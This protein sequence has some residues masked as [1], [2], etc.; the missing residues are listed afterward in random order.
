MTLLPDEIPDSIQNEIKI[1]SL[2]EGYDGLGAN[3]EMNSIGLI[4]IIV[5]R[6]AHVLLLTVGEWIV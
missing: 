3:F 4:V 5:G 2:W 6:E 1:P